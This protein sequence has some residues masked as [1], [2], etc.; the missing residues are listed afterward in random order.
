MSYLAFKRIHLPVNRVV[1]ANFT[2]IATDILVKHYQPSST[3]QGYYNPF[4]TSKEKDDRW[5]KPRYPNTALQRIT[6]DTFGDVLLHP[7]RNQWGWRSDYIER[8]AGHLGENLIPA[9]DLAVWLFRSEFWPDNTTPLNVMQYLFKEYQINGDEAELLFN[10]DNILVVPEWLENEAFAEKDLLDIIGQPPGSLPE[11][12]AALRFLE[13]KEIGPATLFTYKPAERLNIITGD[14]SLGKTF[15]LDTIWWALTGEPLGNDIVPRSNVAKR[16]PSIT[17]SVSTAGSKPEQFTSHYN[18]D[19][20]T[21]DLPKKRSNVAGLVVYARYDNSFA[22][23]DPARSFMTQQQN[24]STSTSGIHLLFNRDDIWYGLNQPGR[25]DPICNGLLRDWVSWQTSGT[26][27][28][29]RWADFVA[30]LRDISPIGEQ[31]EVGQPVKAYDSD[32]DIPTIKFPYGDVPVLNASAGVQRAISLAYLLVWAWYKHLENSSI[33]RREP[34][35]RLVLVIDEVEAHLHPRWQRTIVPALMEVISELAP[36]V[37]P[38]IH[39]ATHSP[40][41]MASVEAVF[42]EDTDDLYHL[43]QDGKDVVLEQLPFVKRGRV[44]LWLMS[45][46]FGLVHARSAVAEQA[47]EDAKKIQLARRVDPEAV[48]AI[49]ERLVQ[50]LAQDDDFWPRWRFFA[51]QHGVE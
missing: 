2:Q 15:L 27:F 1:T 32:L 19:Y 24:N 34:Q 14:N 50:H 7:S 3:Y 8:L 51:K 42:N 17:F 21:W 9:F 13:L 22:V 47:L 41:I 49:N 38:Q 29:D 23:W 10:R 25:R 31:I 37:S 40:M 26:R 11:E 48:R 35:R 16:T 36:E 18:W 28:E 5:L 6:K 46:V 43:K 4:H 39:L 33:I 20:R 45:D 44:D 30:C 12:G